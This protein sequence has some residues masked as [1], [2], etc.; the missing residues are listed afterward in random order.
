MQHFTL[1]NTHSAAITWSVRSSNFGGTRFGASGIIQVPGSAL[2]GTIPSR[3]EIVTTRYVFVGDV[4]NTSGLPSTPSSGLLSFFKGSTTVGASCSNQSDYN[5]RLIGDIA[6]L[7]GKDDVSGYHIQA[8]SLVLSFTNLPSGYNY[9]LVS[10]SDP[11]ALITQ[12]SVVITSMLMG[13]FVSLLKVYLKHFD[14]QTEIET[15]VVETFN[16]PISLELVPANPKLSPMPVKVSS[17]H[18]IQF[19]VASAQ[20]TNPI[21][22]P[23]ELNANPQS[24]RSLLAA[25]RSTIK[26]ATAADCHY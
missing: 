2:F 18:D 26:S 1:P 19:H 6:D 13:A 24:A 16:K 15:A 11:V 9:S 21:R 8:S 17:A 20:S 7:K 5:K 25:R 10:V 12:M 3:V 23:V 14:N 4:T 22:R